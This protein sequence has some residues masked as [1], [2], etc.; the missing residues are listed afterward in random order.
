MYMYR[1]GLEIGGVASQNVNKFWSTCE[2]LWQS[3]SQ[4]CELL[5]ANLRITFQMV[6]QRNLFFFHKI[7]FFQTHFMY[8]MQKCE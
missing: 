8:M 6:S 1:A 3:E 2:S 5:L 7:S 4:N